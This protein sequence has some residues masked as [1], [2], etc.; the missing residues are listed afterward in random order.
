MSSAISARSSSS[1][2]IPHAFY[3]SMS[4]QMGK[5]KE[6]TSRITSLVANRST[7]QSGSSIALSSS[8]ALYSST[9]SVMG[10]PPTAYPFPWS[11]QQHPWNSTSV[12][13]SS[14][15][16][17]LSFIATSSSAV[18]NSSTALHSSG[19]PVMG[20]P[21]TAYPFPWSNQQYPWMHSSVAMPSSATSAAMPSSTAM[22]NY[23]TSTS[24]SVASSSCSALLAFIP[25]T[26]ANPYSC[27]SEMMENKTQQSH[28]VEATSDASLDSI[29]IEA[30]SIAFLGNTID[31]KEAGSS[32]TLSTE[33]TSGC[34]I[35]EEPKAGMC[36]ESENELVAYYKNYGKQCGFE[37][38]TK[39]SKREKDVTIKYVTLGCARGGKAR[40][41]T[42]NVSKPRPTSKID[43]KAM[44]NVLLKNG[45]LCVTSVFNTYNHV[46]S[47]RKSRF[48]KCNREVSESVKRVLDTNDEAGIR[49]NKSFQAIV[50]DVGEFENIPFG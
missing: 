9:I 10:P 26:N 31:T 46:L 29:E 32:G 7:E 25:P 14:F 38:M 43:C 23:A 3:P 40:N 35:T 19:I 17:T 11:N 4:N 13:T 33:P 50:T 42:S 27:G 28:S 1:K 36:F 20:P 18:L 45:K 15:V 48:F 30:Q 44:M 41:R 39:R 12:V 2:S 16:A 8:A 49:I 6:D 5:E 47:P 22:P 21:P 24:S 37:I 34:D